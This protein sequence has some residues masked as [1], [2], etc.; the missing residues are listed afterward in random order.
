MLV[1]LNRADLALSR[2]YSNV[3]RAGGWSKNKYVNKL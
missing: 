2:L 3:S 1:G